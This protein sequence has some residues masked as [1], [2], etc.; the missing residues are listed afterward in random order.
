MWRTFFS[1]IIIFHIII[2]LRLIDFFNLWLNDTVPFST[3]TWGTDLSLQNTFFIIRKPF[4]MQS[5]QTVYDSF[6]HD[7]KEKKSSWN[8]NQ[9]IPGRETHYI[10]KRFTGFQSRL[11]MWVAHG[12]VLVLQILQ[13][14]IQSLHMWN[15]WIPPKS[16]ACKVFLCPVI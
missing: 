9:A 15:K 14:L 10:R 1:V 16:W 13:F 2:I 5:L 4:V 7:G 8:W 6:E 11:L 12:E 3:S